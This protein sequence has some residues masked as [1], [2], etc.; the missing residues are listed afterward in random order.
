MWGNSYIPC[1]LVII[2]L[3]FTC[4][5]KKNWQSIKKSQNVMSMIVPTQNN[6]YFLIFI[7]DMLDY[8]SNQYEY[9]VTFWDLN[10]N[11]AKPEMNSFLNMKNLTNL[12]KEKTWFKGAGS[13]I[14]LM[15]TNSKYSFQYSSSIE[16]G[17]SDH[18]HLTFSMMKNKFVLEEPTSVS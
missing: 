15:L 1:L 2:T 6:Q 9:K 12:I 10:M 11:P 13:C 14:D 8:Y 17:L 5:E 7:S 18:D 16:T 4:G 3:R